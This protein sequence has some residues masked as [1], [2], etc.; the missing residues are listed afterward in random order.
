[1]M[2]KMNKT[3]F[4][5]ELSKR[6]GYDEEMCTK[7]NEIVE[8]TFIFGKN[9]KEKMI[10]K[11]TEKLGVDEAKANEIYENVSGLIAGGIKEKLKHPFK[12]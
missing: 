5:K 12:S 1:M 8:D 9:N 2:M 4:I 6:T 11:F 3:E 10:A 7:I